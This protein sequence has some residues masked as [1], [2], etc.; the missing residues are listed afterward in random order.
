MLITIITVVLNGERYLEQTIKSVLSQNYPRIE[1]VVVDGGSADGTVDIIRRYASQIAWWVSEP[2]NGIAEAMNKGISHSSG[3]YLLFLHSDD[4]LLTAD[5]ITRAVEKMTSDKDLY[6]FPIYYGS[7]DRWRLRYSRGFTRWIRFK[8]GFY[9][10]GVFINRKLFERIGMYDTSFQIAMDYEF[11]LRAYC[12][13]A[14]LALRRKPPLVVMRDTGLSSRKDWSSLMSRFKEERRAHL[15]HA[16]SY[17]L[18]W[19]YGAYW[20]TYLAY[21]KIMSAVGFL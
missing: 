4:Y 12:Y 10:Q 1:Y 16:E 3:K 20:P 6:A 7:A 9:H 11:F 8:T 14:S 19:L 18:T 5:T 15:K 2:D 21:R 13:G 17:P